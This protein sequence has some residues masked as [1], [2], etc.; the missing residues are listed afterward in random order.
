MPSVC[1]TINHWTMNFKGDQKTK[2]QKVTGHAPVKIFKLREKSDNSDIIESLVKVLQ[3]GGVIALP[4]DTLYGVACL[5][6]STE[7]IEKIYKI[8]GRNLSKPIAIC[9]GE[10]HD[11]FQWGKFPQVQQTTVK[12][13]SVSAQRPVELVS[14]LL[15]G[16][17]TLVTE[18][19]PA[20]NMDLNP[21]TELVGIRVPDHQFIRDL[22]NRLKEPL[23]LTSANVSSARS[24]LCLDDFTDLHSSLDAIV[25][26]GHLGETGDPENCRQGSTVLRIMQDCEK[27]R[28]IR[29]GCAYQAT[30][31]I[32]QN[33]WGLKLEM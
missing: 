2:G 3:G 14:E 7:A 5:A 29:P 9:V 25:D 19:T 21:E 12:G 23:A 24:P 20:L 18:R 1:S 33:K 11:V 13:D 16:P 32:L 6:Q 17:V 28:I 15:P 30:V 31:D 22:T 26:G 8:K 10:V 4:T 27:F